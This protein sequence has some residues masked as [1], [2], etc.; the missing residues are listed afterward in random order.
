MKSVLMQTSDQT[1]YAK[2][3]DVTSVNTKAFCNRHGLEHRIFRGLKRGRWDWHSCFNRLYMFEELITEGHDGWAIYLDADA[4]IVDLNFPIKEYLASKDGSA[5]IVVH[6]GATPAYWDINSGV[7]F[8]NLR[9]PIAKTI[10][11][12]WIRRHGEIVEETQYIAPQR[13]TWFGDQRLIQHV[14][15]D[16][17]AWFDALHVES[18]EVMNSM[19]ASFIKHHIRAMTPDFDRRLAAVRREVDEVMKRFQRDP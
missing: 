15:R 2:M 3:L 13:P 17:R 16:N 8:L 19:H 18:Q 1:R 14:L 9:N 5:G 7:M 10:V 12:D 11:N 6:S 4:F